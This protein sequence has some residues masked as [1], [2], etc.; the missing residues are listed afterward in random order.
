MAKVDG[1]QEGGLD[2]ASN[3]LALGQSSKCI[4]L[5]GADP[6]SDLGGSPTE[7]S[8]EQL[9]AAGGAGFH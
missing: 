2:A 7:I 9:H 8:R 3:L 4:G 6:I 5:C 1:F